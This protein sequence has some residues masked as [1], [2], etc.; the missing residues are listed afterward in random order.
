[1][2]EI[3]GDIRDEY[4]ESAEETFKKLNSREFIVEGSVSLDDLN[5]Y[6]GL[7]L[8][9][10]DYGSLGGYIIEQLDRLPEVGDEVIADNN[11]RLVVESLDKNRVENVH[12]YLS[13]DH[14]Y[15]EAD[16]TE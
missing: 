16:I 13:E 5:D 10:D 9:S 15:Q 14:N 4:D 12:V 1:M 11:V 2:E 7:N 6:L 8:E 3:V